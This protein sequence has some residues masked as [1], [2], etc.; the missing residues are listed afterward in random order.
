MEVFITAHEDY[1]Y[2]ELFNELAEIRRLRTNLRMI[3]FEESCRF[4]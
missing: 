2:D 3:S 4:M 1:V